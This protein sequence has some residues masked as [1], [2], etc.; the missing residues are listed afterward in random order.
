MTCGCFANP[1]SLGVNEP[2]LTQKTAFMQKVSEN[3]SE[4]G[5]SLV[6]KPFLREKRL[7]NAQGRGVCEATAGHAPRGMVY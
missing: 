4:N 5:R 2:F 6:E 7:S 1:S 3:G